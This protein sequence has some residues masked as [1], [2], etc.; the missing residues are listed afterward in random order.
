MIGIY[1]CTNLLYIYLYLYT[2]TY[3]YILSI[4]T[5]LSYLHTYPHH[6]NTIHIDVIHPEHTYLPRITTPLIPYIPP[7]PLYIYYIHTTNLYPTYTRPSLPT[8]HPILLT[9]KPHH[10]YALLI[11]YIY[12]LLT[13]YYI[14]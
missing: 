9:Y 5:P 11:S 14:P 13:T 1:N 3:I 2:Y 6:K 12:L 8:P 4:P 10:T 7:T